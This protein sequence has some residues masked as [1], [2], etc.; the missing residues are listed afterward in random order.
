MATLADILLGSER[1]VFYA[2]GV[3]LPKIPDE[4]TFNKCCYCHPVLADTGGSEDYKN[5]FNGF[6]YQRQMASDTCDFKLVQGNGTEITIIDD[7]YGTF[8]D[9]GAIDTNSELKTFI[10]SWKKVID[11]LGVDTYKVKKDTTVAGVSIVETSLGFD[12]KQYTTALANKTI[13]LDCTQDGSLRHLSVDFKGS[14]YVDSIRM[15]GFFGNKTPSYTQDNIVFANDVST[16]IS[17][18]QENE[19]S[20]ESG[21]LPFEAITRIYDEILLGNKLFINDY[22]LD[23]HSYDIVKQEVMFESN[24]NT[25]F[26]RGNRN[27]NINLKFSDRYKNVRK[28]NC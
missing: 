21:L 13:R 8:K 9:F 26:Y 25:T 23:N 1:G 11:T 4:K 12:L 6:Y 7:T 5:D 18:M 14:E 3:T 24:E 17:M 22:N 15:E 16:Q 19:Y 10:V 28:E 27:A 2:D 20:M